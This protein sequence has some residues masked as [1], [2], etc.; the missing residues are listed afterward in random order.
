MLNSL[1][2]RIENLGSTLKITISTPRPWGRIVL[3]GILLL[4]QPIAY[5]LVFSM[6]NFLPLKIFFIISLALNGIWAIYHFFELLTGKEV[7]TVSKDFIVVSNYLLGF[8]RAKKYSGSLVRNLKVLP[9]T[10]APEY[11][12]RPRTELFWLKSEGRLSFLYNARRVNFGKW[13]DEEELHEILNCIQESF[14][15]YKV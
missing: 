1:N 6:L 12:N 8:T 15:G 13:L 9:N 2:H 5:F 10:F 11:R 4:F 7:V 3:L 14:P